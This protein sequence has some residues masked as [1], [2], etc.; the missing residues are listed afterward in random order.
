MNKREWKRAYSRARLERLL[1]SDPEWLT[2]FWYEAIRA[3]ALQ[4]DAQMTA[5]APYGKVFKQALNKANIDT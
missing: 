4:F 5:T 2:D 1:F 3:W